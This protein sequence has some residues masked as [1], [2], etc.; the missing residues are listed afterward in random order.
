MLLN[1]ETYADAFLHEILN[2]V[3]ISN[4]IETDDTLNGVGV[5]IIIL[6]YYFL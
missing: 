1:I 5:F 4:N 6:F 3:K 2:V